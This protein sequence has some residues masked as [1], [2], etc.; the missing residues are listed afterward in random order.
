R[1]DQLRCER[2]AVHRADRRQRECARRY[3][4]ITDSRNSESAR[5]RRYCVGIRAALSAPA[6]GKLLVT[7]G[8][9]APGEGVWGEFQRHTVA[10]HDFDAIA[11]ASSGHGGQDSTACVQFDGKH[12]SFEF[13]DNLPKH[14]NGIF[15][16]QIWT[17]MFAF[18]EMNRSGNSS[19]ASASKP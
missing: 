11:P 2:K 18:D 13:L 15:F 1:P 4:A 19:L 10:I 7:V 3:L 6:A 16:G 9:P 8:D 17:S 12:S 14:F 5:P